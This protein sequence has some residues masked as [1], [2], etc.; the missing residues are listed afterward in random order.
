MSIDIAK[1]GSMPTV[2]IS[3][4]FGTNTTSMS[5]RAWG[6]Q[7]KTNLDFSVGATLS[8]PIFDNRQ[9]KTAVNK[10]KIQRESYLLDLQ[11]QQ[12]TLYNTIETY[13]IDSHTKSAGEL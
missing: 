3:G 2:G 4:G 8:I 12:K 10:A 9:T 1:S 13:W 5:D 6:S 11:D 7:M